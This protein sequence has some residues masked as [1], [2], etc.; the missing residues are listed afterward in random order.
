LL[1]IAEPGFVLFGL[2]FNHT[3]TDDIS[4]FTKLQILGAS[5]MGI[6]IVGSGMEWL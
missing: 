4:L 5:F 2:T 1:I 6:K 3:G